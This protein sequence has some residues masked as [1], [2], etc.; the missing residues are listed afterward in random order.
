[1]FTFARRSR[2]TARPAARMASS[3]TSARVRGAA[4]AAVEQLEDRT[5]W[6]V[7]LG[8]TITPIVPAP[9]TPVVISPKPI[10]GQLHSVDL[11]TTPR[12]V[13]NDSLSNASDADVF[14]VY[15]RQ[16]DYLAADVDPAATSP[17]PNS[18]INVL[19]ANGNAVANLRR[20]AEPDTGAATSNGA[21]GFA[22]PATGYYNL[23]VTSTAATGGKYSIDFHRVGLAEGQQSGKTLQTSGG[24]YAAL[25]N[26]QLQLT[27]PTGY[28]FAIRGNW[29]QTNTAVAAP[30]VLGPTGL[31][32]NPNPL[33]RNTRYSATYAATGTLYL[34][35][36]FG[37]IPFAVPQGQ[38]FTVKT[39]P[40]TFGDVFGEVASLQAQVGLPLG[41]FAQDLR[42]KLGLNLDSISLGDKWTIQLGS[43]IKQQRG[44]DQALA[45]VP[46]IV[47]ADK[48]GFRASFGAVTVTSAQSDQAAVIF[49][50][51]ADPALYVKAKNFAFEGSLHGLVPYAPKQ[52]FATDS[53]GHVISTGLGPTP[54]GTIVPNFF[55]NVYAHGDFPLAGL[56]I[57]I[58]GDV[59][60][61]LDANRNGQW[62]DQ[63]GTAS[64]LFSGQLFAGQNLE[65]AIH[66]INVG[67][68]GEADFGYKLAGYNLTVPL[69]QAS[70]VFSGPKQAIFFK[71]G[72]VDPF[73]GT[74][75]ATFQA[76]TYTTFQGSI[77]RS[78]QFSVTGTN[79]FKVFGNTANVSLTL[80]NTGVTAVASTKVLGANA[81]LVGQI[82]A[83]GDFDLKGQAN[84]K[85]SV[86]S[87]NG[88][89]ELKHQ[90]S[91]NSF[92][93]GV[94]G[95]ASWSATILGA[96]FTA[97]ASLGGT[98][99]ITTNSTGVHYAG[100][101]HAG[102][103]VT[104]PLGFSASFDLNASV[105]NNKL[106]FTFPKLGSETLSLP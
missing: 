69:G 81:S 86:F 46:Y 43:Q 31:P 88:V 36:A 16:G 89:F 1:M 9:P 33:V 30:V 71:G 40:S 79:T 85:F 23:R 26:G 67:L 56:P 57:T 64:Q 2:L 44:I 80:A 59:T 102:G 50:D 58:S 3:R 7:S 5:L 27:G 18:T 51:P 4:F 99:S 70:A 77:Y 68:N 32:L 14:R 101:V 8:S 90:G 35:T 74:P 84:L 60:V 24:L 98:L 47:Y 87:G 39:K 93:A 21:V 17:L 97:S 6:S 63:T 76:N 11:L 45:A 12:Q 42:N 22:A 38:T 96:K 52:G 78:G 73:Q 95:G 34:E 13:L 61:D 53:T 48:A 103:K 83:N 49:A 20:T 92:T 62:L 29:T 65:T 10:L 41:N 19:D 106:T 15:L 104:G 55:G 28:G 91:T 100:S 25:V 75:L 82:F 66:D 94:T 37:E 54:A 105:S 72:T